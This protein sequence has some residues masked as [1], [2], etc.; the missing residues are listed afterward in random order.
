MACGLF[1]KADMPRRFASFG[2]EDWL[3]LR[4]LTQSWK[5]CIWRLEDRAFSARRARPDGT[6]EALGRRL[7]GQSVAFS[8]AY[9]NVPVIDWQ[10]RFC[11]RNLQGAALAVLD[12]SSDARAGADIAGLCRASDIVYVPLPR[13]PRDTRSASRSK[14]L[15]INWAW[16]NLVRPLRPPVFAFLDHDLY[17]LRPVDLPALV[18]EQPVY[19]MRVTRPGGWY[20]WA[21]FC[22]F[23]HAAVAGHDLDFR[24]DWFLG[25]DTGGANW[26]RLYRGLDPGRLRFA[27]EG[28]VELGRDAEG[29]P[30]VADRIDDW[31]HLRH[32][33]GWRGALAAR[34]GAVET[35]VPRL[36]ADPAAVDDVLARSVFDDGAPA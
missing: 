15:A 4:P 8:I 1:E 33:S 34:Q 31:L 17:P 35:L 36:L 16:R 18:A 19:G 21:G 7:A 30:V 32:M 3:H 25:L 9:N 20:L 26:S 11:R 27:R 12:N 5:E 23:R 24:Q 2:F 14:A 13:R 28:W 29:A 6:A 22:V 10:I